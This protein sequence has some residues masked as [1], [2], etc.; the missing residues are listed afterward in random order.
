[1]SRGAG[2]GQPS[3]GGEVPPHENCSTKARLYPY[4]RRGESSQ[5]V[6]CRRHTIPS[7]GGLHAQWG[8]TEALPDQPKKIRGSNP[9]RFPMCMLATVPPPPEGESAVRLYRLSVG[10]RLPPPSWSAV[11]GGDS[12][13]ACGGAQGVARG[14]WEAGLIRG[15]AALPSQI[16]SPWAARL[17]SPPTPTAAAQITPYTHDRG[18]PWPKSPSTPTAVGGRGSNRPLH[19]RPVLRSCLTLRRALD[20]VASPSGGTASFRECR[21]EAE[22]GNCRTIALDQAQET[23][24]HLHTDGQGSARLLQKSCPRLAAFGLRQRGSL[25]LQRLRACCAL[26]WRSVSQDAHDISRA[27]CPA[28]CNPGLRPNRCYERYCRLPA[29]PRAVSVTVERASAVVGNQSSAGGEFAGAH[30]AAGLFAPPTRWRWPRQRLR[31]SPV[32]CHFGPFP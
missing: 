17:K 5:M 3:G 30:I 32:S 27:V 18:R 12:R 24:M 25:V 14:P 19:P 28:I 7:W 15:S 22:T 2:A 13:P 31:A 6:C 11:G 21:R 20:L 29:Q 9:A 4:S 1:M 16:R 10:T 23:A 26:L 8:P